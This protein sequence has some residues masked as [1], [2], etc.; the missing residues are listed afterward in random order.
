MSEALGDGRAFAGC[1]VGVWAATLAGAL[2]SDL[3]FRLVDRPVPRDALPARAGTVIDLLTHN[4]P[5]A[6]WP[7]A[8]VAAGWPALRGA[9][10]LGDG[11]VAGQLLSHGLLV[12]AYLGQNA[13][14]A[15]YLPHLAFEWVAFAIP[16]AVWLRARVAQHAEFGPP[17]LGVAGA[18]CV[19]ALGVAAAIETYLVPIA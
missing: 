6:L 11:L 5:V 17:A 7:L 4:L 16:A 3:G 14:L 1:L 13:E 10:V 15:R 19:A 2:V 9:R 8:L 18:W 12:G